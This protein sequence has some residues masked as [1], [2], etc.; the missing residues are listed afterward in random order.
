MPSRSRSSGR[1]GWSRCTRASRRGSRRPSPRPPGAVRP[2][3]A[4]PRARGPGRTAAGRRCRTGRRARPRRPPARPRWPRGGAPCCARPRAGC[5]T[6]PGPG[7][8][9]GLRLHE[10]ELSG[11]L[12]VVRD[13][14][15][16]TLVR[17]VPADAVLRAVDRGLEPKAEALAPEGIG[18]RLAG[19]DACQLD[20]LR[21]ALDRELAL[22]LDAIVVE[23]VQL[24]RLERDLRV[25]LRV[26]EV[27]GLQ[28]AVQLLVLDV[29]GRDLRRPVELVA[30]EGRRD[31]AEAAAE[32]VDARVRDL[33]RDVRVDRIE[34]P[35]AG[36]CELL[37]VFDGRH[38][39]VASSG[40]SSVYLS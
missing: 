38:V 34:R 21:D 40:V 15:A 35:G 20:R 18:R 33:E 7:S 11:E 14:V 4:G 10:R 12:H 36:R 3:P 23:A 5:P 29:D 16:T 13:V 9:L 17:H 39:T 27:R 25:P 19:S 28:V 30:L 31:L 32:G 24:G 2:A 8:W 22:A 6:R 1:P 26:E 37:R